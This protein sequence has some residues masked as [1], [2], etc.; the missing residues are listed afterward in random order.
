MSNKGNSI[1]DHAAIASTYSTQLN[2]G[3]H[4]GCVDWSKSVSGKE[5]PGGTKPVRATS[6][7]SKALSAGRKG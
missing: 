6:E 1:G 4:Q 3:D 2:T 7:K 5:N